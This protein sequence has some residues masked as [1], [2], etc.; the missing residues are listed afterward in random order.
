MVGRGKGAIRSPDLAASNLEALEGLLQ[1]V[2]T[3]YK[4][5]STGKIAQH[6][7]QRECAC[8]CKV[9]HRRCDFVH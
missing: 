8:K 2:S 1:D 9:T 6:V 4:N 7:T 3:M 5:A